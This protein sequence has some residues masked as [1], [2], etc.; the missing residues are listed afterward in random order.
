MTER[1]NVLLVVVACGRWDHFSCDGYD[2]ETTPFIDTVA[3][4]GVRFQQMITTAPTPLAAHASLFTGVFPS[5]HGA[6]EESPFLSSRHP[7]LPERLRAAGYRTAAFCTT[8]WVS[9]ETGFGR[10]FDVFHTQRTVGRFTGPARLYARKARDRV[11]GRQDAGARRTNQALLQWLA[12]GAEPFFAF[13]HYDEAHLPYRPPAP[14]DRLFMPRGVTDENVAA[15]NRDANACFAGAVS[16]SDG[17]FAILTALYDGALRYVDMRLKEVAEALQRDGLWDRTLLIVTADHGEHLGAGRT[18]GHKFGL[19]DA[20]LRVPLVIR[21]PSRIP[22]GYLVEEVAQSVDI[23]PT[24]LTIA[25]A[26]GEGTSW[27]GRAL[28]RDGRATAGPAYAVAERFRPNL[29]GLRRRFP[30]FDAR[31]HDVRMKAIR[32]RKE[33]FIW[34]SDEA[35]ELYDLTLDPTEECNLITVRPAR[36]EAQRRQL[37]DWFATT[38]RAESGTQAP[39]IDAQT[40]AQLDR[41][42]YMD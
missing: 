41:L 20:L 23:V 40:R 26:A 33:K 24:V 29:D 7:L 18:I 27:S 28:F 31:P 15:V 1:L 39:A 19:H 6:T 25:G 17:D 36:A 8:D 30:R 37:F 11:L 38:E 14:Y 16:M 21:C 5:T 35:N 34:R 4:Q 22:G 13:V 42:G 9:P 10:G 32:T 2:R 3:R 12:G